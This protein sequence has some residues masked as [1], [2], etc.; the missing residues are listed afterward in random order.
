MAYGN[1]AGVASH[2]RAWT[3]NGLFV[4]PDENAGIKGTPTTLTEVDTWLSQVSQMVDVALAGLGFT[5]PVTVTTVTPV[6]ASKVETAVADLVKLSHGK[7]R[8]FSERIQ[9]A[10][11]SGEAVIESE[12]VTWASSKALGFEAMGVP[13]V[14]PKDTHTTFAGSVVRRS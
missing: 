5:V 9:G 7:G 14:K 4:D 6:I 1:A 3:D 10:G 12:I 8:L 13:R 2:T 11:K